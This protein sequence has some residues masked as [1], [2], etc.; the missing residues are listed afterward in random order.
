MPP[1][2]W[3]AIN[4][5]PSV[6]SSWNKVIDQAGFA[7]LSTTETEDCG[8][9][10]RA[11]VLVSVTQPE[12][13]VALNGSGRPG[14]H[15]L[16]LSQ[17]VRVQAAVAAAAAVAAVAAAAAMCCRA[18]LTSQKGNTDRADLFSDRRWTRNGCFNIDAVHTLLQ[19]G[20]EYHAY[21]SCF[22]Y[23]CS[24]WRL[25]PC[26]SEIIVYLLGL[27]IPFIKSSQDECFVALQSLAS[28]LWE[29]QLSAVVI[30]TFISLS[31]TRDRDGG[32]DNF[33]RWHF[34]QSFILKV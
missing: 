15:V 13:W 21:S 24:H 1:L 28:Y 27:W 7:S 12:Q 16:L 17:W 32:I 3:I 19:C 22:C 8:P 2:L 14:S 34:K 25:L 11:V 6:Q 18:I 30:H 9:N 33:A 4:E 10:I 23:W 5:T 29:S 26:P 20:W 31:Q